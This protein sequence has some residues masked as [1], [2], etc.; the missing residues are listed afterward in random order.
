MINTV[1]VCPEI[2]AKALAQYLK[3]WEKHLIQYSIDPCEA[4]ASL[5]EERLAKFIC[6]HLNK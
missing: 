2:Y 1:E 4:L 5:N 6:E 3:E